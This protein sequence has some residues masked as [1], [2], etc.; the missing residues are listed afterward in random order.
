[1]EKTKIVSFLLVLQIE[2]LDGARETFPCSV[3]NL[4]HFNADCS[5]GSQTRTDVASSARTIL[6]LHF[7]DA[8]FA[9]AHL[10]QRG[11]R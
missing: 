7:K 9:G 11:A 6:L 4:R 3:R 8:L 5:N 10:Q 1:M 2:V